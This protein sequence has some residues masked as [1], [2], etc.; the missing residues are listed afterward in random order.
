[1]VCYDYL[2]F[3]LVSKDKEDKPIQGEFLDVNLILCFSFIWNCAT[4]IRVSLGVINRF[5]TCSVNVLLV[6][7]EPI[8]KNLEDENFDGNKKIH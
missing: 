6:V 7:E 4:L 2:N 5:I 1:M 8:V 3:E